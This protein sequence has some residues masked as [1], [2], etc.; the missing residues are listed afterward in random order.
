MNRNDLTL[1]IAFALVLAVMI[2]WVARW[3]F[4]RLNRGGAAAQ[5]QMDALASE[6]LGS[7]AAR[8][9]AERSLQEVEAELRHKLVQAEAERDAAIEGLRTVRAEL[10]E[11]EE[12]LAQAG[13]S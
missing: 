11:A 12:R 4:G 7:E 5:S 10:R 8:T 1:A 2:G 3:I 13:L 6:L 9:E